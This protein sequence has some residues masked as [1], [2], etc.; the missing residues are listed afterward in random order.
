MK[1][2]SQLWACV[3]LGLLLLSGIGLMACRAEADLDAQLQQALAEAGVGALQAGPSPAPELVKLGEALF[4]DKELSGN[5]DISCATCHHPLLASGDGLSLS[6]GTGGLGLG[7]ARVMG[8]GRVFIPRNAIEVFNRGLPQW[9]VIFWDGRVSGSPETGFTSPARD[10]LPPGLTNVLAVQAMFPVTSRDEMRGR[11]GDVDVTGQPN[12]LATIPDTEFKAIWDALMGRLLRNPQYV[13][14]FG[15]AFPEVTRQNLG[16]QH[17]ANA[18]AAYQTA[19]F[20]Y[21][22]S[23]WD[24]YLAG[25]RAA[26]SEEAKQGALLFY[27]KAGCAGCHAGSLFTDQAFHN[28]CVPQLG[29]GKGEDA[30]LDLGR[31]RETKAEADRFAFRTPPLR[32]VAATGPWMHNGAYT[33]LEAAV[34]HHLNPRVALQGYDPQQLD[35][36]L[37]TTLQHDAETTAA[38]MQTLDQRTANPVE[39]SEP[40]MAQL[41][42]LLNALTS[43]SL[44]K[45]MNTIPESVPSGLPV[46]DFYQAPPPLVSAE[47]TPP[48]VLTPTLVA[49]PTITAT[50]EVT[51]SAPAESEPAPGPQLTAPPARLGP[52][53]AGPPQPGGPGPGPRIYVVQPGDYVVKIARRYYVDPELI[54]RANDLPP[55][56]IIYPGQRLIIP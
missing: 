30:P 51:P 1:H 22:D 45:L 38:I 42:A 41:L 15:A 27:G 32:N 6:I 46:T 53:W 21:L 34:A 47:P 26:L 19:T 4:F 52:P 48:P 16:F 44:A 50:L 7:P 23:P 36:A 43:P 18:M 8:Q 13:A 11:A 5:R 10:Q 29:P 40:E 14:L 54:I 3:G 20:T 17:A 39:L 25:D 12:E 31:A 49:S 24:R 28:I 9:H 35:P 55:S 2:P 33:T 56:G 37:Q